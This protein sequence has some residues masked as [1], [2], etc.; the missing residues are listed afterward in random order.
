MRKKNSLFGVGAGQMSRVDSVE[1]AVKKAEKAGLD[2][3]G[4]VLASDAFFPFKDGVEAAASAGVSAIVQPGGSM[5]D[6]E[7]IE[8][9]DEKNIGMIFTGYRHFNH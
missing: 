5:R 9:A 1:I 6:S 8:A 4:S 7:V 2:L 3:N